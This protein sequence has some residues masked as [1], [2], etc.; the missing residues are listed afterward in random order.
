MAVYRDAT[1]S[2]YDPENGSK[3]LPTDEEVINNHN[4][5]CPATIVRCA[6]VQLLLRIIRKQSTALLAVI[7]EM[8]RFKS[9]WCHDTLDDIKWMSI[10]PKVIS[11]NPDSLSICINMWRGKAHLVARRVRAFCSLPFANLI[12]HWAVTRSLTNSNAF[13]FC[14]SCDKAFKSM[15][16]LTLHQFKAHGIKDPIRLKVPSTCC[17]IC[18]K[19]FWTRPRIINHVKKTQTCRLNL[20]LHEPYIT[21]DEADELDNLFKADNAALASC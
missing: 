2:F 12:H 7:S 11:C 6:R 18:L 3:S 10:E 5:M 16:S 13:V 19:E 15:Q 21:C 20:S 4:L 1:G 14:S 8:S 17:P 9:G